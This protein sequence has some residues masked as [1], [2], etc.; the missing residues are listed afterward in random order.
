MKTKVKDDGRI[1]FFQTLKFKI[2]LLAEVFVIIA[3]VG[4]IAVALPTSQ[5]L[6]KGQA[7]SSMLSLTKSYARTMNYE[8]SAGIDEMPTEM[9]AGILSEAKLEGVETSYSYLVARD[10]TMLYHPTTDKIGQ[11]VENAAVKQILA[12]LDRGVVPQPDV[13]TYE[14]KGIMKYAAYVVLDNQSILVMTADEND[15]LSGVIQMQYYLI[16]GGVILVAIGI[17]FSLLAVGYMLRELGPLTSLI[18]DTSEFN[19]IHNS[20]GEKIVQ[21]K[22]EIGQMSRAIHEMRANL[23]TMVGNI[24]DVSAQITSNVNEVKAISVEINNECTDNS[25]TTQ[26]LAAGMEETAATT[27]TISGNIDNMKASAEQI[28][29]LASEGEHLANEV[30][31]RA[32]G[33]KATTLEATDRTTKMYQ[34]ISDR[35]EQAIE[36]SKAVEKINELTGVIMAISS[37]T[38]LLALNA[39]IEAARAGDAGK[40]FAVVAT[41]IG[42]LAS[43]TSEAVG[44]INTIVGDVNHA[45]TALAA[46]LRDTV[47]FLE[48]V[49][50]KDYEQFAEVGEH[51]YKD[52][53]GYSSGM[54]TIEESVKRLADTITQIAGAIDGINSTVNESTIGVA[55]IADKT[56]CVVG[57][58][59]QNNEL[60]ENCIETVGRLNEISAMFRID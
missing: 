10:S 57:Q 6:I 11:P 5:K 58:T 2:M 26:Q 59:V 39:S 12:E 8:I 28:R 38:S 31:K 27:E 56:T 36:D 19:F 43:Q 7:R 60:V 15:I 35:T 48:K 32:E 30:K 44:S 52:S 4:C 18:H 33:L 46:S 17:V 29:V 49:V 47:D 23:R 20:A 54:F 53:E 25:A 9:L 55:E 21:K 16:A 45:V 37:Q 22:D 41:E 13:I 24:E 1:H 14:F 34:S 51:Y 50:L 42:S 40:G 3:V